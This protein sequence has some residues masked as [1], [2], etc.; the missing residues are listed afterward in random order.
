MVAALEMLDEFTSKEG[1]PSHLQVTDRRIVILGFSWKLERKREALRLQQQQVEAIKELDL[2]D[3]RALD[4]IHAYTKLAGCYSRMRQHYD[5]KEYYKLAHRKCQRLQ[6]ESSIFAGR[7]DENTLGL[8]VMLMLANAYHQL[9]RDDVCNCFDL[10]DS[11]DI[12]RFSVAMASTPSA[13]SR[14]SKVS[15]EDSQST[16]D[17]I[18]LQ[19]PKMS[20]FHHR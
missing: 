5:A 14:S 16:K 4:L 9:S 2:T 13:H 7:N 17:Q 3:Q 15:L 10:G 20:N 12:R 19:A 8:R 6:R 1:G 11:C 18:P